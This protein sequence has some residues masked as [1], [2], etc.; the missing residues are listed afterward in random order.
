MYVPTTPELASL[1]ERFRTTKA[2]AEAA[3]EDADAARDALKLA[4]IDAA[5]ADP[6][7]TNPLD[8]SVGPITAHLTVVESWRLDTARIK[9]E[10]PEVYAAYA[11]PST[12][13]KLEL[14]VG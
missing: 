5:S 2:A 8:V 13:I 1:L 4:M 14:K 7:P 11:K 6:S 10:Q 3:K 9:A 12:A